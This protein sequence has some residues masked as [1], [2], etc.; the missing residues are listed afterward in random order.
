MQSWQV[1]N[2]FCETSPIGSPTGLDKSDINFCVLVYFRHTLNTA[3]NIESSLIR[4]PHMHA[5]ER[6]HADYSD[7]RQVQHVEDSSTKCSRDDDSRVA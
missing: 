2:T 7:V 3:C 4:P 1:L 5:C 6:L